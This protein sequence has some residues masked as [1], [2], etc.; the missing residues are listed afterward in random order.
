MNSD[1]KLETVREFKEEERLHYRV[2][3][4]GH[5][6]VAAD[7]PMAS[8]WDVDEWPQVYIL[9][10]QG[11]IRYTLKRGLEVITAVNELLSE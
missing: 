3:W 7:G 1:D 6:D 5:G 2:W 4:D 8:V 10:G 11:L 9:D